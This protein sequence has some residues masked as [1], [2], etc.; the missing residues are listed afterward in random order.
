MEIS[1]P[2]PHTLIQDGGRRGY[3]SIGIGEGGP[4]DRLSFLWA[5]RLCGNRGGTT[6][7]EIFLGGF[8]ARVSTDVT[9]A[10]T[11]ADAPMAIDGI[12]AAPWRTH[13]L[14]GGS[15]IT[16]GTAKS[17]TRVYLAIAGG[18]TVEPVFHSTATVTRERLGGLSGEPLKPGDA[19]PCPASGHCRQFA[20][21]A[22]LRPPI[23][24]R[25]PLRV[26]PA[27][28]PE[29]LPRAL[30]KAFFTQPFTISSDSS[31][32]GFRLEGASLPDLDQ[33]PAA[34]LSE[35][36]IQGTVQ[37]PPDGTP[38]IMHCDHQT[39]GGY[40]KLGTV[41]IPDLWRL[42]QMPP[43]MTVHFHPVTPGAAQEIY[44]RTMRAYEST[45][46]VIL[47]RDH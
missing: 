16:I 12:P 8:E 46:P 14:A 21:G 3:Y 24:G 32:M 47:D 17:G 37:I 19:L 35:G 15:R 33:L 7:L 18:F 45:V 31:R 1:R 38:I 26:I 28:R 11:G 44:R 34:L 25:A 43:G 39:I 23:T 10:V 2:G 22:E 29:R 9:I 30:K 42:A 40:A 20:L 4:A 36:V 27:W 5:N 41:V 6:A 13:N